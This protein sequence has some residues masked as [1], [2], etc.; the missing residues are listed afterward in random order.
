MRLNK[1]LTLS[2]NV[3]VLEKAKIYAD[4]TG[5]PFLVKWKFFFERLTEKIYDSGVLARIRGISGK[6]ELPANFDYT[7]ELRKNLEEK[8]FK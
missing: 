4:E 8:H 6:I 1:K 7:E 5:K 3:T 2:L